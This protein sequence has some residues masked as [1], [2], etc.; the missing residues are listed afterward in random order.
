[1]NKTQKLIEEL[2]GLRKGSIDEKVKEYITVISMEYNL[3]CPPLSTACSDCWKDQLIFLKKEILEK[4]Q[5]DLGRKYILKGT[6]NVIW[7]GININPFTITD[8]LAKKYI[9]N[10]FNTYFFKTIPAKKTEQD[11]KSEDNTKD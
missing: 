1:M 3:P 11:S 6:V 10:G 4:Y 7:N 9:K 5:E 8:K 2:D